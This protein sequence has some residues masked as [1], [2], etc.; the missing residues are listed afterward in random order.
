MAGQGVTPRNG[1]QKLVWSVCRAI[2]NALF[3]EWCSEIPIV[4]TM[5]NMFVINYCIDA[6]CI[7]IVTVIWYTLW[8][9]K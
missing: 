2:D 1:G 4:F 6:M 7:T 9:G 5:M 3:F 8:K